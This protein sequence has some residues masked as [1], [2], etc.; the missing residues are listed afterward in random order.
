MGT[1]VSYKV[2]IAV[3]QS[4]KIKKNYQPQT[5]MLPTFVQIWWGWEGENMAE[6]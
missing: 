6:G 2:F 4:L 1:A 5:H 3:K